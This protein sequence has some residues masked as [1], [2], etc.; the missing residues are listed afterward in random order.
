MKKL[1]TALLM[2]ISMSAF[3]N[4]LSL[5]SIGS[6]AFGMGGAFVALA[7]DPSA[8][9]WNP[10]GMAGQKNSVMLFM[11]DVIPMPV[12]KLDAYGIDAE[13][14]ANHY[15]SPNIMAVYNYDKFAFGLGAYVPA[16]L[17]SEWDG[18]DLTSFG[19]PAYFDPGHTM[20]NPYAGKEFDW[21][22]QIAVFNIAPA[23]AYNF[24]DTFKLG[25]TLNIFYGMFEMKR[26]EDMIDLF[27]TIPGPDHML[28]T[29]TYMDISGLGVG[30]T[31]G[32]MVDYGWYNFGVTYKTP[33]TVNME[34]TMDIENMDK[35]DMELEVTW[36]A[37]GGFGLAFRPFNG[38]MVITSDMQIT[39]W[40][41]LETLYAKILDMQVAPGVY[42]DK[43]NE[44]HLT[45]EDAVQVRFGLQFD[46]NEQLTARTGYY[47]D[48]AP[49]PDKTLNILFPSST[50]H[51]YT[52]GG[53]YKV[54]KFNIDLGMEYLIGNDRNVMQTAENMPGFHQ[55]DVF[56]YSLALKYDF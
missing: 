36:P 40:K 24:N 17:G 54:N 16:G 25:A 56:A 3:A 33:V 1:I 31:L 4:G 43:E 26:G 22:S 39:N 48:P 44:L 12:Y 52:F 29:Q 50:N 41:E 53:T 27:P 6:K 13:G 28:D 8:I 42:T 34:G 37:W 15:I 19:G 14:V 5:N 51:A 18:A 32:F 10:A 20:A 23:A 45:W 2:V 55:M 38:K 11:T 47:F 49:A 9:H 46:I 30:A 35:Y 7:D 21:M